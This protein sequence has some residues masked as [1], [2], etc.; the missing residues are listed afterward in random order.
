VND[1]L[2]AN[3][4]PISLDL[5]RS[6]IAS[7]FP[8]YA[9]LAVTPLAATGSTNR[10]FR[11]GEEFLIRLPRQA[12][13]GQSISKERDWLPKLRAHLPTEVPEIVEPGQ[14][15]AGYP[16]QWSIT[17]WLEG[18]LPLVWQPGEPVSPSRQQLASELAEF[19]GALQSAP[20]PEAALAD[21][22][23]RAYRG[24]PLDEHNRA[25]RRTLELCRGLDDL[26]LDLDAAEALWSAA[27]R[28]P[29]ARTPAD[30]RWYH[31]D[32]VAENLLLRNGRLAAVLDFGGLAIGDPT[33]DLHGAWE[34]FDP[35][36]R[37]TFRAVLGIEE[38]QWLRGRA[39]ALAIALGALAYYWQT[40][41][42]RRR[43]RLAMA[44]SV[45]GDAT[46]D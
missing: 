33:I 9:G 12:D 39:W 45:L 16:E 42:D 4:L 36:A 41:P 15:E 38:E 23:L 8:Q 11:L 31:S 2:H 18:E 21:E 6:L 34:L 32:L 24:R 1:T 25:F 37:Q 17:R 29:G 13:S 35:P 10:L 46:E 26:D 22:S 27:L 3:E 40:M 43:D 20:I 28:L 7:Q 19:I 14:P 5:V 30:D 44:R